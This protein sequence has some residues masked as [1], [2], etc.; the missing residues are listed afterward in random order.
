[1]LT[2]T[3]EA[4]L[5]PEALRRALDLLNEFAPH[6]SRVAIAGSIRRVKH[7]C[8]DIELVTIPLKEPTNLFGSEFGHCQ[9]FGLAV[10]KYRLTQGHLVTGKHIKFT[11]PDGIKVDLF[12]TTA[13]NW[14]WIFLLRT[15][16]LDFNKMLI[17]RLKSNGYTCDEGHVWWKG[18][19]LILPD[20]QTVFARAGLAFVAPQFRT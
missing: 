20:E 14:G 1:M 12:T 8:K 16:S 11:L 15:G 13:D 5:H 19:P 17:A 6:C 9:G 2:A 18:A 7:E 10:T 4:M 3:S